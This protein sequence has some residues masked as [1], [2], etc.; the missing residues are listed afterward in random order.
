MLTSIL[1]LGGGGLRVS[2]EYFKW[3]EAL[4]AY[5]ID[6]NDQT[7]I[8]AWVFQSGYSR[9]DSPGG[10]HYSIDNRVQSA[11][12]FAV[13]D[14]VSHDLNMARSTL[15]GEQRSR[16]LFYQVAEEEGF[17]GDYEKAF[18][19]ILEIQNEL[20]RGN[21]ELDETASTASPENL[22]DILYP[23]EGMDDDPVSEK[24]NRVPLIHNLVDNLYLDES[25]AVIACTSLLGGTG[26]GVFEY[27]NRNWESIFR[28]GT[29]KLI[30]GVIP[31][32]GEQQV[33]EL[34]YRVSSYL[35]RLSGL[36]KNKD[37]SSVIL[38][39]YSLARAVFNAAEDRDS[40][41]EYRR[42]R[43]RLGSAIS[44]KDKASYQASMDA[45]S[46][47]TAR[48]FRENEDLELD[49][50][51]DGGVVLATA[52]LFA[53][54]VGPLT[55]GKTRPVIRMPKLLDAKDLLREVDGSFIV[56][57]YIES[58]EAP[59]PKLDQT[60]RSF[61]NYYQ[62]L[63]VDEWILNDPMSMSI[64][65]LG[66]I[67]IWSGSLVPLPDDRKA[68]GRLCSRA[69]Y[70]AWASPGLDFRYESMNA[71]SSFLRTTYGIQDA[72]GYLLEGN[73]LIRSY[74]SDR[75]KATASDV[76]F[77]LWLYLCLDDV[78]LAKD[79]LAMVD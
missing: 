22:E 62:T 45:L 57:C 29:L 50:T 51:V 39:D 11:F 73:D 43:L 6:S 54:A 71:L 21:A 8:G 13:M 10:E 32:I 64:S 18:S 20:L 47:M 23:P 63:G 27:I 16:A 70:V 17:A 24:L 61:K 25:D 3:L 2:V 7:N 48:A 34:R 52:P 30:M 19:H 1:G 58:R 5:A 53:N 67:A 76:V 56:P 14:C 69:F 15:N 79:A 26:R 66:D 38:A 42:H 9:H 41:R 74:T 36:V 40:T 49:A 77:R 78:D 75:F 33:S 68:V 55:P 46:K 37:I 65:T 59:G 44:N 72:R 12:G 4:G 35:D 60:L 28:P 31:P